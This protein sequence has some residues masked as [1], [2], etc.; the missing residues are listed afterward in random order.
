MNCN[1]LIAEEKDTETII[2]AATNEL[3]FLNFKYFSLL[4]FSYLFSYESG[5]IAIEITSS[6]T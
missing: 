4:S 6:K 1:I 2:Y 5:V 3:S